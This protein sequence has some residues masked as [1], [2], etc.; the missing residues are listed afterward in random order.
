MT[1]HK[2]SIPFKQRRQ[3]AVM[4]VRL[5][6]ALGVHR[7]RECRFEWVAVA[8]ADDP[9]IG[10]HARHSGRGAV[11]Y[12]TRA[13]N[14]D[15]GDG[16]S[17]AGSVDP[18]RFED[19]AGRRARPT[20]RCRA[21]QRRGAE[22]GRNPPTGRATTVRAGHAPSRLGGS[23]RGDAGAV[24]RIEEVRFLCRRAEADTLAR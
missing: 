2:R 6:D 22:S 11:S 21:T 7:C 8:D 19:F 4:H 9:L 16:S 3:Q 10:G 18:R 23:V 20:A 24:D 13:C 15:A 1:F 12:R 5:E 17:R 14:R